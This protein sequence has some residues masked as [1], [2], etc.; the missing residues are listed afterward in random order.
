MRRS[1]G[2]RFAW[3]VMAALCL[4]V[5]SCTQGTRYFVLNDASEPIVI[6]IGSQS[7]AVAVNKRGKIPDA[8]VGN[9]GPLIIATASRQWKY[10][11]TFDFFGRLAV[12][13]RKIEIPFKE[14]AHPALMTNDFWFVVDSDGLLCPVAV[15]KHVGDGRLEEVSLC[16]YPSFG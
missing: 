13:D 9:H 14:Y 12:N 8:W 3:L 10:E 7:T 6:S 4:T 16:I 2:I 15:E 5:W 1:I 11:I